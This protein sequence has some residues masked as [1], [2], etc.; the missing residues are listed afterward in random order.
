MNKKSSKTSTWLRPQDYNFPRSVCSSCGGFVL[1]WDK[2]ALKSPFCP[3]C[4]S[5]MENPDSIT[6]HIKPIVYEQWVD[7][8]RAGFCP[9]EPHIIGYEF[10]IE[11]D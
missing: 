6:V 8:R 10:D 11:R 1:D 7:P 3:W 5:K 4:G 9:I 2:E